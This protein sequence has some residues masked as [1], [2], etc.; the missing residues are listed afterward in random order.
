MRLARYVRD[1]S[2]KPLA[3]ISLVAAGAGYFEYTRTFP[4]VDSAEQKKKVLVIPFNR[5]DLKDKHTGGIESLKEIGPETE[6]RPIRLEVKELVDLIHSAAADPNIVCLYGIF[7]HGSTLPSAGWADLEEVR[8]ALKVFREVHRAHSEP[9]FGQAA[10]HAVPNESKPLYAYT[11]TFSSLTDP[12][13]KEYYLASIFT[14][15]HLQQNGELNLF[16]MMTQQLFLREL[17]DKHGVKLHVFKQGKYK[18]FPNMFTEKKFT[19]AHKENVKNILEG[20]N[21]SACSDITASRSM[22]LLDSWLMKTDESELWRRIHQSGTF[23]SMTV[24]LNMR[25]VVPVA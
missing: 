24:R 21:A 6:D 8:N 23:P 2:K 22:A 25:R 3:V 16:G 9:N 13:N 15:L 5:L 4:S 7:G 19:I 14:H 11:D 12:G 18:N 10:N 1:K 20:I 17:L